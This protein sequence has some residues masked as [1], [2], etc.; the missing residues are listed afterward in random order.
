MSNEQKGSLIFLLAGIYG[1]IFSIGLPFGRWNEP[2]PAIFPFVLSLLLCASGFSWLILGKDEEKDLKK[3]I[4]WKEVIKG[5][6]KPI[7]VVLLTSVFILILTPLG[8]L[9][10]ASLYLFI[11]FFWIS[12][13]RLGIA[14]SLA[15]LLG[16]GSWYCFGKLLAVQLPRGLLPF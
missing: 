13:Y 4:G 11:V 9:I 7:R 1:L 8:F 2:G 15:V 3:G 16:A 5:Q 10:T 6:E 12:R 14:L